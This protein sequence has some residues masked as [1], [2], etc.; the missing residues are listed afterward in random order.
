MSAA[1]PNASKQWIDTLAL[2]EPII[3]EL[4]GYFLVFRLGAPMLTLCMNMR[5]W[6]WH[7]IPNTSSLRSNVGGRTRA[8]NT[9]NLPGPAANHHETPMVQRPPS[10]TVFSCSCATFITPKIQLL[11]VLD[12]KVSAHDCP[13]KRRHQ[14]L[15]KLVL[16][17]GVAEHL[18]LGEIQHHLL[19]RP[20]QTHL[21]QKANAWLVI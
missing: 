12:A 7:R 15:K 10:T 13:T 2:G 1:N 14:D 6:M 4:C 18:D 3:H 21:V 20:I 19:T 17:H 9:S 8:G 16:V 11:L 5:P